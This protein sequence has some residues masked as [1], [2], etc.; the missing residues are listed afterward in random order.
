MIIEDIIGPSS[1]IIG[2][3]VSIISFY[4]STRYRKLTLSFVF[5][6]AAFLSYGMAEMYWYIIDLQGLEPYQTGIDLIYVMYYSFAILHVISTLKALHAKM[7]TENLL[8]AIIIMASLTGIYVF[9]SLASD[10]DHDTFIYG[11]F[12]VA[13]SASLV[14]LATV[15]V[16][17]TYSTML[18]K[19]WIFIGLAILIASLTDVWYYTQENLTGYEYGQFPLMDG[20]WTATDIILLIGIILHRRKI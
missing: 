8:L 12:F 2:F 17:K 16:I 3:A 5:L 20:L 6:G 18:T 1:F 9:V 19:S 14:A 15:T 10:V 11:G 4:V 7:S 13:L